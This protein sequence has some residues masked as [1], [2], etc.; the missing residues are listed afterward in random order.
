MESMTSIKKIIPV[1][2]VISLMISGVLTDAI[3]QETMR[4]GDKSLCQNG[5]SQRSVQVHYYE[6]EKQV[7]CEVQYYKDTDQPGM[8][9]VLWQAANEAGFCEKKMAVFVKDL[10]DSGWDCQQETDNSSDN[11][12]KDSPSEDLPPDLTAK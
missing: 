7:P 9:Q 11:E 4:T 1:L 3:G 5:K 10:S 6:P 8:G 12:V 2:I